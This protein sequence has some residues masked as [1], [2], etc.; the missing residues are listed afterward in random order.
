MPFTDYKPAPI[1]QAG[2][3]IIGFGPKFTDLLSPSLASLT[4]NGTCAITQFGTTTDVSMQERQ[5]LCDVDAYEWLDKR[6]RKLD[7]LT[8]RADPEQQAA[9]LALLS[10]DAEVGIVVRPY[11]PSSDPLAAADKVWSF[12][13]QVAKLDPNPIAVGNDYEWMVDFYKVSRNLSAVIAA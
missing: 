13:A 6:V 8:F 9:I 12:N 3:I 1:K 7:Q 5:D 10:E 11:L 2:N 4:V